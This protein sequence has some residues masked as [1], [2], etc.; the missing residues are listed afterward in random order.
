MKTKASAPINATAQPQ[1][2][3][4][5]IGCAKLDRDPAVELAR[6]HMPFF[7]SLCKLR[8]RDMS[9]VHRLY[10]CVGITFFLFFVAT[11]VV[12][13]MTQ[14]QVN[15][16]DDTRADLASVLRHSDRISSGV[17]SL[18]TAV[19]EM[20]QE[21]K[22][23]SLAEAGVTSALQSLHTDFN[24]LTRSVDAL[25]TGS[26]KQKLQTAA[27][28][29]L[30]DL[31]QHME[32]SSQEILALYLTNPEQAAR[33][34]YE[35]SSS[36]STPALYHVRQVN[37][38]INAR[39]MERQNATNTVMRWIQYMLFI[40]LG[41]SLCVIILT[42]I[43]IRHSLRHDTGVLLK[44]LLAMAKGDLRSQVGLHAKDEIGSIGRLV[45]YVVD[46]T[47]VTLQVMQNDVDK[48]YEMV[49]TNRKSIDAT[50]EAIS[51]QRNT[52]QN[53]AEATAQMESSV[54]KVTEF[55]RSTLNEVKSA[56]EASD[57]CRR[58]MQDNIT[59]TH[60]LSDRLRASSEAINKIHMM[61]SQIESIVKTIADIADQTNLLAL[62][63]T[64]ESARA[65]ESGR[66]FAIVAEE[67]R[68][69]A[70]K[71]AKSTQEVSNTISLLEQAVTN[72]VNVMAACEGEM[73]NSLQQSSRA[74]SS[75]EEI[76]GIIATI[77]DM[78]EQIVQS[79]QQ[80][81]SA[82]SEI[83]QSIAHISR[84]AED[85]YDQMSELQSNMHALNDL[86][87]NQA[88]VLGKFQLKAVN[89]AA[90][91]S[92]ANTAASAASAANAASAGGDH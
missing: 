17:I 21:N 30:K 13:F 26:L 49:N 78:S 42:N 3:S 80:Q 88:Q 33:V 40:G 51:V 28:P 57:T 20:I 38:E 43:T 11:F 46:N 41:I 67:V 22:Q 64:I 89:T 56:E 70:I 45:D 24:N 75:I 60:T 16:M 72:S 61:S 25:Q 19:H 55:A 18:E 92:D 4:Q 66:G 12:F 32:S 90:S 31:L 58:T 84:L 63:A 23:G 52:A 5:D 47:N 29:S 36:Y 82:A 62:N 59:T 8:F 68:E 79:C 35:Q 14:S 37:N 2:A 69:L 9:I 15:S 44:R 74:N 87:T 27:L 77:S 73:D 48:L 1:S 34:A 76:M 81:T 85:S 50:N 65:G 6:P 7:S 39:V 53:V 86:A 91:S 10:M 83:N 54:E 71:T